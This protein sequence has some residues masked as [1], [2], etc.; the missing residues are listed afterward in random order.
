M[1]ERFQDYFTMIHKHPDYLGFEAEVICDSISP[2][3][4]RISTLRV[5]F[6]RWMLAEFNTHRCFSR[7]SASSRAIPVKKFL[8]Q[9]KNDPYIPVHWGKNQKGMVSG[10]ELSSE[11]RLVAEKIWLE[12][13][14]F[15]ICQVEKL[16]LKDVWVDAKG[17]VVLD[18][19]DLGD[20]LRA[21]KS[22]EAAMND[23][24]CYSLD[25]HKEIVNRL[26][27][28]FMWHTALVTSTEWANFFALRTHS[29]ATK[30]FQITACLMAD[31]IVVSDPKSLEVGEWHLPYADDKF[32]RS[33]SKAYL[34]TMDLQEHQTNALV[35]HVLL[36]L[37]AGRCARISYLTQDNRRDIKEDIRLH[38]DLVVRQCNPEEDPA[39]ASPL[40]HQAQAMD[41]KN[42]RSG[43]FIGFEQYRK[44][45]PY[46]NIQSFT[47]K[48]FTFGWDGASIE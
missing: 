40:E 20:A 32:T 18:K 4:K 43:N 22:I 26:M 9:V 47:Y 10:T 45:I 23:R 16:G 38:D 3:M 48:G 36:Q 5:R 19:I 17:D 33:E 37:S 27:E 29:K 2:A 24:G 8:E 12:T 11:E 25:I 14:D 30:A 13:R 39:H 42:Y 44:T 31:A 7:N 35:D 46:E 1:S 6:P 15:V 34:Q 21:G 41:D 28:P